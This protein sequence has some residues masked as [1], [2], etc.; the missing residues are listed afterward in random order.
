MLVLNLSSLKVDWKCF[1]VKKSV[2][3]SG[4]IQWCFLEWFVLGIEVYQNELGSLKISISSR[5]YNLSIYFCCVLVL[6]KVSYST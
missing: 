1:V 4:V 2:G 3:V 6:T 5:M